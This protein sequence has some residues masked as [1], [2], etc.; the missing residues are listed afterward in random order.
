MTPLRVVTLPVGGRPGRAVICACGHHVT[1][2]PARCGYCKSEIVPDMVDLAAWMA[3]QPQLDAEVQEAH[4][5][6]PNHQA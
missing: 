4:A 3:A 6:Y 2:L 1:T 5:A